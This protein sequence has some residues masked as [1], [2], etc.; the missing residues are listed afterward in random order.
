MKAIKL[1]QFFALLIALIVVSLPAHA[2]NI[3]EDGRIWLNINMKTVLPI[4]GL[5]ESPR[6]Q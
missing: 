1:T 2:D 4:K 5:N 3:D 6:L